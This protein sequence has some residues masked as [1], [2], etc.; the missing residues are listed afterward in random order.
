MKHFAVMAAVAILA[1]AQP[2]K[3]P[4][5]EPVDRNR[6][7]LDVTR[8][9][10]LFTVS[11]KKGRF[12]TDLAKTD[13]EVFESKKSQS[14]TEFTAETDLPLRLAILIDTSNSIRD[15]FKFQQEAASDFINT[16]MRPHQDKA[17]VVSFDTAAELVADL[18]D[19]TQ[20][21][22][23]AIRGLRPGGGTAMYDAIFFACRDKLMM[24]Q[25]K[26]KFRRAMVVLSDG[27]DNQSRWTR[28]QA[29]EIA[30]K[31]DVVI[32]TISTNISRIPTDGDKILKY[33]AEQTGGLAFFPFKAQELAQSFENI[34]NELRHQYN[35]LY[36]PEPL[37]TDG[38]YHP[39]DVK[40]K[41]RRDLVVRARHGYY[42]PLMPN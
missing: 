35:V 40:V 8:V 9:Q 41:G 14:I 3:Q 7:T 34:A 26:H 4:P 29:L 25:P 2:P 31:A 6:I 38:M 16:V 27:E 42:A 12:V 39:V 28:D 1:V 5:A 36:R 13:F 22:T 19:D 15:R 32:Y 33:F 23:S 10:L 37:K 17:V 18:T 11:D 20:K 21:L 30:H 24:D